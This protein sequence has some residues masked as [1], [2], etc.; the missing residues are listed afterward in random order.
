MQRSLTER[1]VRSVNCAHLKFVTRIHRNRIN[2]RA[3]CSPQPLH[4]QEFPQVEE[5]SAHYE[6]LKLSDIGAIIEQPA[7]VARNNTNDPQA[8]T[9]RVR[10]QTHA[11]VGTCV[12]ETGQRQ[13]VASEFKTVAKLGEEVHPGTEGQRFHGMLEMFP[14]SRVGTWMRLQ[15]VIY[16]VI[17][18]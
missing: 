7:A 10:T 3:K 5:R 15:V 9:F 1:S 14:P 11:R 17:T 6:K 2:K 13:L 12:L 4:K 18:L 8:I 16:E